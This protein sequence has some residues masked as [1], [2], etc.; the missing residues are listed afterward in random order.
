MSHNYLYTDPVVL[1]K[2]FVMLI[3]NCMYNIPYLKDFYMRGYLHIA[4]L[5]CGVVLSDVLA[6][7]TYVTETPHHVISH[8]GEDFFVTAHGSTKRVNSFDC[9]TM[10]ARIDKQALPELLENASIRVHE[11][12]NGDYRLSTHVRGDGG[13]LLTTV[14]FAVLVM[15]G[16]STTT[17]YIKELL[18]DALHQLSFSD[19]VTYVIA[20]FRSAYIG[21]RGIE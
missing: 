4:L 21:L 7:T 20:V 13:D 14:K 12:D 19:A 16:V 9:D 18:G 6:T 8:D 15:G 3:D 11:F 1:F 10:L 17:T 2:S 5:T